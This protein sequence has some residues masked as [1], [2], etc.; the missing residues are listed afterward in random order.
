[1]KILNPRKKLEDSDRVD[2]KIGKISYPEDKNLN[3]KNS[4]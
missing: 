2:K 3:N 4:K 1:M